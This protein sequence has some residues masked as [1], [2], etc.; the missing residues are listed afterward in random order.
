[1]PVTE[2]HDFWARSDLLNSELVSNCL[3][4]LSV[5]Y[6]SILMILEYTLHTS[7]LLTFRI[8]HNLFINYFISDGIIMILAQ[9]IGV[10]QSLTSMPVVHHLSLLSV[11]YIMYA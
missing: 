4:Y 8:F 11:L 3:V 5:E 6:Q 1:M 2:H 10:F 7:V 9:F